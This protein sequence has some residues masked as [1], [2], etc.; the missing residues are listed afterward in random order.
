MNTNVPITQTFTQKLEAGDANR[1]WDSHVV[2]SDRDPERLPHNI[3]GGNSG[4]I[5]ESDYPGL[6]C[7]S[8]EGVNTLC[9]V[10]SDLTGINHEDMVK[11]RKS[12]RFL[13]KGAKFYQ[14]T[15]EMHAIVAPAEIRF[16]LWFAGQKFS[17]NHEPILINWDNEGTK[18]GVH[19]GIHEL[20]A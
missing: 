10:R 1:M 18:V 9:I 6:T 2:I 7:V 15:F 4:T 16:E 19:V 11:M 17:G 13:F 12:K 8:T 20:A 5:T 14:C 3:R